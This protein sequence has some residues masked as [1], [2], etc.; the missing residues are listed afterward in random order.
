MLYL[1]RFIVGTLTAF[2]YMLAGLVA[3]IICALGLVLWIC[4]SPIIIPAV[5]LHDLGKE[6]VG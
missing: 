4:L 5:L 1:K 3:A 6:L 2:G